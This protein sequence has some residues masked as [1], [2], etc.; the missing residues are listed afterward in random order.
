MEGFRA[1]QKQLQLENIYGPCLIV[2][3][4]AKIGSGQSH[5]SLC[6]GGT[7]GNE[8]IRTSQTRRDKRLSKLVV[9]LMLNDIEVTNGNGSVLSASKYHSHIPF[10]LYVRLHFQFIYACTSTRMHNTGI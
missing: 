1:F 4:F 10:K 7:L 9:A 6:Y 2:Y 3:R 5:H 8:Y